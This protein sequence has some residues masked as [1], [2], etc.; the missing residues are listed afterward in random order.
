MDD[1]L[2]LRKLAL[3][4]SNSG[5]WEVTT[6][7]TTA[8]D[9]PS[10]PGWST[11]QYPSGTSSNYVWTTYRDHKD[12]KIDEL[13]A[14]IEALEEMLELIEEKTGYEVVEEPR[15]KVRKKK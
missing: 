9:C 11:P 6:G 1:K 14:R 4:H 15:F 12:E 10:Y 8:N 3:K 2:E 7:G 13:E 5:E